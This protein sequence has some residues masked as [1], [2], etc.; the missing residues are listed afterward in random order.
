MG[1]YDLPKEERQKLVKKMEKEIKNDL[2]NGKSE[3]IQKYASDDDTYIRKNAYLIMGRLYRDRKDLKEDVLDVSKALFESD[4]E[5][6]RQTALYTLGEIGKIDADRIFGMFEMALSDE[7]RS[8]RNAVVGTL[9]QMGQKN[10][11]PTLEFARRFLHHQ[12]PKIRRMIVHGI[13]L[14]GR[15]HPEDILPLLEELQNDPDRKVREMII[16]VLS[17]IS[18]KKGCLE[19][20]IFALKS[21]KNKKLVDKA[22]KEILDVHKRYEKFAAKSHEEAKKY[23]EQEFKK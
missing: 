4:N 18:Y 16:H 1:F 10:P 12:D 2:K 5:K 15:T 17:Q 7:H 23:V 13:E 11:E 3:N 21:W 9:K 14:R 8:V 19:K 20:V 6:I 22:L